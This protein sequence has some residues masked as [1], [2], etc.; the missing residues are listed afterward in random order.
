MQGHRM[1]QM[2]LSSTQAGQVFTQGQNKLQ[3]HGVNDNMFDNKMI[4]VDALQTESNYGATEENLTCF[5]T[6]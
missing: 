2:M 6:Y 1:H 3:K 5:G 4:V